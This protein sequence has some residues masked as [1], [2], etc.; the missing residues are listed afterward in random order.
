LTSSPYPPIIALK[1]NSK[2]HGSL[3]KTR[4]REPFNAGLTVEPDPGN[5][6]VG[7]HTNVLNDAS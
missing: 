2:F 6:G 3:G 7:T 4:L 5:A 1:I